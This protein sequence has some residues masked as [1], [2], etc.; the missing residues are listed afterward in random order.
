[1]KIKKFLRRAFSAENLAA[2]LC[3][4]AMSRAGV[5]GTPAAIFA[6]FALSVPAEQ[7]A[8]LGIAAVAAAAPTL[9]LGAISFAGAG[10][11]AL[12]SRRQGGLKEPKGAL[13]AS[14]LCAGSYAVLLS[15]VTVMSGG[16]GADVAKTVFAAAICAGVS[17][18]ALRV[19]AEVS[20]RAQIKPGHAAVCLAGAVLALSGGRA[21]GMSLGGAL[22]AYAVLFSSR[23]YGAAGAAG[24]TVL[25]AVGAGLCSPGDFAAVAILGVPG[26]ICGLAAPESSL[27]S[28][29]LF[30][31]AAFPAEILFGGLT[32]SLGALGE[33]LGAASAF[34]LT[35]QAAARAASAACFYRKKPRTAGRERM[36]AALY[37][38][39]ERL[40]ELSLRA[41]PRRA[42]VS[43]A[44]A[45]RVCAGCKNSPSC[46]RDR[47]GETEELF[48]TADFYRA[49]PDCSHIPEIRRLSLAL[50]RR[51]EYF[52]FESASRKRDARTTS[53]LIFCACEMIADMERSERV[54]PDGFLSKRLERALEKRGLHPRSAAVFPSGRAEIELPKSAKI[55]RRL[56]DTVGDLTGLEYGAAESF[57]AGESVVWELCPAPR[58]GAEIGLCQLSA[59]KEASGDVAESF[60]CGGCFYALLSDG[61]GRGADARASALSLCRSVR[62]LISAGFGPK[63][64]LHLGAAILKASLPEESFA[65]LDLLKVDLSGGLCEIYKAGGCKSFAVID[66][67][68]TAFRPGGSPAGII[69]PPETVFE[70]FTV[71]RTAEILLMSDG[72]QEL[73]FLSFKRAAGLAG[74]LPLKER[75]AL[76]LSSL[77]PERAEIRDDVSVMI[78]KISRKC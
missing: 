55:G 71:K 29:A 50:R 16:G 25:S 42:P 3:G 61:M 30:L 10:L 72:A 49:L 73:D 12:V 22:A 46:R 31:L 15:A 7:A 45:E 14:L 1:M 18:C 69:N 62:E 58:F 41:E 44:V 24:A 52:S 4:L 57:E 77:R 78:V 64:A 51:G 48:D 33:C 37:S 32:F 43:E 34:V 8:V 54:E 74:D 70:R 39:S 28:A 21:F 6:A 19:S 11:C 68:E 63:T 5:F 47:L 56:L 36:R 40:Y 67:C 35:Y 20:G 13:R 60:F 53:D 66:G 2:L 65:T 23:K 75:A 27:K 26:V 38:A 17:Y 59:Q 76:I 9:G